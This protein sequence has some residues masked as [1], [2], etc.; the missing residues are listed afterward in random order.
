MDTL[1]PWGPYLLMEVYGFYRVFAPCKMENTCVKKELWTVR[2]EAWDSRS[3]HRASCTLGTF[4]SWQ[5]SNAATI[6]IT[7]DSW[8]KPGIW[9]MNMQHFCLWLSICIKL[10]SQDV[11]SFRLQGPPPKKS[12]SM[13]PF[14]PICN[15]DHSGLRSTASAIFSSTNVLTNG[16]KRRLKFWL[17]SLAARNAM[18]HNA[19][20]S[21]KA[22]CL[23]FVSPS[24]VAASLILCN[25][26]F[27]ATELIDLIESH[28]GQTY[29]GQRI[30][31]PHYSILPRKT[32]W[33]PSFWAIIQRKLHITEKGINM[34]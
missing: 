15:L 16:I 5:L 29:H 3:F 19:T 10:W 27:A 13:N 22:A 32:Y 25:R 26:Y 34:S 20:N 4:G 6:I 33:I 2:L 24:L 9:S 8:D 1:E 21:N 23:I 30:P 18:Q 7:L 31:S 11:T 12:G 28:S 17:R 14:R